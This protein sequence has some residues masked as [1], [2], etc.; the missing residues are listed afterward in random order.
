MPPM[1]YTDELPPIG[2]TR[3]LT[4]LNEC[5]DVSIEWDEA[6]DA[7]MTKIIEHKMAAG[8]TFYIIARRLP[9]QRGRVAGPKKLAKPKDAMKYRVLEIKDE[10]F[11]KFVLE[12][13]GR[14]VPT[15]TEPAQTVKRAK[16]AKEVAT[17][18]SVG[19]QPRR[20]G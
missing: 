19:V 18:H 7:A 1:S 3:C 11:S 4:L 9:G 13:H 5:G 16:S 10:D 12:G 17:S 15:P 8:V 14:A 6:E 20:G 2:D